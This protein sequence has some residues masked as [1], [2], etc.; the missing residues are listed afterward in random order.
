M[1]ILASHVSCYLVYNLCIKI[2]IK[3]RHTEYDI[4]DDPS[5][6]HL[7]IIVTQLLG[8]HKQ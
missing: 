6:H 4:E 5:V 7:E 8:W 3:Q 1:H 2:T